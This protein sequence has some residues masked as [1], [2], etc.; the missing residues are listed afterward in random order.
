MTPRVMTPLCAFGSPMSGLPEDIRDSPYAAEVEA[1]V[2]AGPRSRH[3]LV[4]L[5]DRGDWRTRVLALSALGRLVR[6]DSRAGLPGHLLR[7]LARL[8]LV[9][10]HAPT[11]GDHGRLVSASIANAT[12]DAAFMVRM[13]AALALGECADA[14]QTPVLQRLL[15]DPFR[16]VRLAA[17]LALARA[18]AATPVSVRLD[19]TE[20]TPLV[21]AEGAVTTRWIEWLSAAH[22]AVID[23]R[24][25]VTLDPPAPPGQSVVDWLAGPYTSLGDGGASAEASRYDREQDLA[26]QLAKPFGP[27]GRAENLQQLS[28]LIDLVANLDLPPGALVLDLGGGSGWVA[29]TLERFGFRTVVADVAMPLLRLARQRVPLEGTRANAIAADMGALP[30]RDASLDAVFIVEALHHVAHL[31][32][33]LGEVRRVLK[34]GA[35]LLLAEPGEGH[36]ESPKSIAESKEHGIRESEIHP[37]TLAS[38][39]RTAG[40]DDVSIVPQIPLRARMRVESL[41]AAM[42]EPSERW[43]V[44]IGDTEAS[45]ATLVLRTTL[46]RPVMLLRAGRPRPD[47]R[48]PSLLRATITPS[49]TRQDGSVTGTVHVANTGDTL[50]LAVSPDDAG[51]VR[52]AF[53][54]LD[55][56]GRLVERDFAR[57]ALPFDVGPGGECTIA[58][59]SLPAPGPAFFKIDL[60]SEAVCWFEDRGSRPAYVTL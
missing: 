41:Q 11:M 48:A 15:A 12:R 35:P 27:T 24:T 25:N 3:T 18:G 21:F 7:P 19:G 26:H 34:P 8:P 55:D 5:A 14:V 44:S 9:R 53:Q 39:A 46:S 56:A 57:F 33:T 31:A 36:S 49:L 6:D 2:S 28:A 38:L 52:L 60:V 4:R 10:R 40:F 32:E 47:S 13:A 20:A 37:L 51:V 29:A 54:R 22:P 59:P 58:V 45:F 42:R 30:F 43:R 23:A 50:W 17:A 1:L 16:P